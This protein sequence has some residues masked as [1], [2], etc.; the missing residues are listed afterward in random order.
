MVYMTGFEWGV[1]AEGLYKT[2]NL[3]LCEDRYRDR[4]L[5][6]A[7]HRSKRVGFFGLVWFLSSFRF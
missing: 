2:W 7:L 6:A 4:L 5:K 1:L 3:M